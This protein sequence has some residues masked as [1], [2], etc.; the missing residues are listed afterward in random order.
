M[1]D[2]FGVAIIGCGQFGSKR[3]NAAMQNPRLQLIGVFDPNH[4]RAKELAH[5]HHVRCFANIY[6]VLNN[7]FVNGLIIS[8]PNYL[9]SQQSI[10]GI[11][12]AKH[13]LCEKPAGIGRQDFLQLAA[14]LKKNHHHSNWQYGYNHR[15]FEPVVQ[16][17]QWLDQ[18]SIGTIQSLELSIASGR[19]KPASSWFMNPEQSGGGTLI[20]NGHHLFDLLLWLMPRPWSVTTVNMVFNRDKKIE[21]EAH[22]R[23]DTKNCVAYITSKWQRAQHYLNIKVA[24]TL[25]TITISDETA[26]LDNAN[27]QAIHHEYPIKPGLAVKIEIE[28]WLNNSLHQPALNASQNLHTATTIYEFIE[29]AYSQSQI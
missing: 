20:D 16:L 8:S 7:S 13:I 26:C 22:V 19:D 1:S 21:T 12:H 27:G 2:E 5:L 3:A 6:E 24:G 28:D 17:K 10:A 14:A 25:G 9:H 15:F 23:L 29:K 11:A 18:K 4:E